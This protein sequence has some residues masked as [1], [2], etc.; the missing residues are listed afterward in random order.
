MIISSD[1]N[2][3][4]KI[5]DFSITNS[6]EKKRKMEIDFNF[7]SEKNYTLLEKKTFS[8]FKSTQEPKG[9]FYYLSLYKSLL[10]IYVLLRKLE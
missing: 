1:E 4:N 9:T 10:Y 6:T 5:E 8:R 7:S 3:T 2:C